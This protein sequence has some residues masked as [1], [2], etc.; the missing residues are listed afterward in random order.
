MTRE[1]F[2]NSCNIFK[3]WDYEDCVKAYQDFVARGV[4]FPKENRKDAA[5]YLRNR[6]YDM[7]GMSDEYIEDAIKYDCAEAFVGIMVNM[8]LWR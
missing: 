3:R 2:I 7:L 6:G 4:Y 8:E 1:D 5:S